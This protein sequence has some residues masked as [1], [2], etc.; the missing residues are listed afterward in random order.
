MEYWYLWI[1]LDS[2]FYFYGD[3]D[4]GS[5]FWAQGHLDAKFKNAFQALFS[6]KMQYGC[7]LTP[8]D[9]SYQELTLL[10]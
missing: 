10:T 6:P 2:S 5:K 1:H 7:Q 8:L 3:L 4:H 9:P